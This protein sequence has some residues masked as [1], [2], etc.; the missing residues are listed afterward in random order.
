V[1]NDLGMTGEI[2]IRGRV[3]PIGGVKEKTL[4]AKNA[5]LTRVILPF[6]NQKDL[7]ELPESVKSDMDFVLVS[8]MAEV[9]KNA[10]AT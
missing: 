6:E 1:K 9:L 7:N 2:T 4:A 5:G 3:L 10:L 8:D